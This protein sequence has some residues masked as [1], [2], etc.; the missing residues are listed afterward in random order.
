MN[1]LVIYFSKFGNTKLVAETI[2]EVL[3]GAGGTRIKNSDEL[4]AADFDGVDLVVPNLW[5]V[6]PEFDLDDIHIW[7]PDNGIPNMGQNRH[8]FQGFAGEVREFVDSIIENREPYPGPQ[9]AINVMAI[10]EAIAANPNGTT[11]ISEEI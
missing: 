7:R 11:E 1:S 10:I 6:T 9:D 2:G 3:K 5:E 4:A 8:F